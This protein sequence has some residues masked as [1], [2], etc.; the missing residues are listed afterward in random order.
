RWLNAVRRFRT[1][2]PRR[3]KKNNVRPD[4]ASWINKTRRI[5]MIKNNQTKTPEHLKGSTVDEKGL[6]LRMKIQGERRLDRPYEST[7]PFKLRWNRI[8]GVVILPEESPE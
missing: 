1:S 8:D 7:K 2:K 3:R 6:P 5:A 4:A